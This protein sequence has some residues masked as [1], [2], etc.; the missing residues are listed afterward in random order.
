MPKKSKRRNADGKAGKVSNSAGL[1]ANAVNMFAQQAVPMESVTDEADLLLHLEQNQQTFNKDAPRVQI[2]RIL[3]DGSEDNLVVSDGAH[4]ISGAVTRELEGLIAGKA[5]VETSIIQVKRCAMFQFESGLF[6]IL[7]AHVKIVDRNFGSIIGNPQPFASPPIV[8]PTPASCDG[9]TWPYRKQLELARS[10]CVDTLKL[11]K[12]KYFSAMT[13]KC[14]DSLS[15]PRVRS[16]GFRSVYI[17]DFCVGMSRLIKD[18]PAFFAAC[19]GGSLTN[20]TNTFAAISSDSTEQP[21]VRALAYFAR[22]CIGGSSHHITSNHVNYLRRFLQKA[23]EGIAAELPKA[24]AVTVDGV[25]GGVSPK[26]LFEWCL[27]Q[28]ESRLIFFEGPRIREIKSSTAT[29]DIIS[30]EYLLHNRGHPAD[31]DAET[32]CFFGS[33]GG[34]CCDC[35]GKT[36]KALG[37]VHLFKCR[38]C[39]LAWYCSETC[40]AES[41]SNGH[42]NFCKKHG[43][44]QKGDLLVIHGLKK[45]GDLNASL[46]MN[47]TDASADGRLSVMRVGETQLEASEGPTKKPGL[48]ALMDEKIFSIKKENLRHCRPLR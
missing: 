25:Q 27:D 16:E 15:L 17:M 12:Q 4:M 7:L 33:F 9:N 38:R 10:H 20:W 41:W 2:V 34:G 23:R 43:C 14:I 35:C 6:K 47:C 48:L 36:A 8:R 29:G 18:A 22:A 37:M 45:R 1:T 31:P 32:S 28:A 21:L 3:D 44:F 19:E 13:R 40:Q 5:L 46:V 11:H 42:R 24:F 39:R 26:K 30:P